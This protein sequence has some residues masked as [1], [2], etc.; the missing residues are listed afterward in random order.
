MPSKLL[1]APLRAYLALIIALALAHLSA[2]VGLGQPATEDARKPLP[3]TRNFG[4][5]QTETSVA[6]L[7]HGRMVWEHVHD[8][9]IGKPYMR[10]GLIDGTELTRPSPFPEGYPKSDHTW[11]RALWWSWKAINGINF[12]EQNQPGTD[13]VEVEITHNDDGSVRIGLTIA[14]HLP[15]QPPLVNEERII[16]VSAPDAK[17]TY[18]IDWQATFI[19]AGDDNV[20]FNKNSYGG[21]AIRMAAECCGNADTGTQ[22]WKFLDSEGRANFNNQ[23]ARWAAYLGTTPNGQPAGV[24]MFDHP[25]NPRH[26]SWWQSRSHYPYLNPSFTCKEDYTLPAGKSL[27]LRYRILVH[28][29]AADTERLEQEWNAFARAPTAD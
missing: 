22:P 28:Q 17:G 20:V 13:P 14:Y 3:A 16:T 5:R 19:P 12:W 4:W 29:G 27:T 15:D 11:H 25:D 6:L 21:M 24:A 1:L 7:N 23:A 18:H 9:K 8:R 10:I 26:P 2:K